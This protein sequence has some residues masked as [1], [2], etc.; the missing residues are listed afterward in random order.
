RGGIFLYTKTPPGVIGTSLTLKLSLE[1]GVKP[2]VIRGK[3][4]R[5][6]SDPETKG[7]TTLGVG[8]SFAGNDAATERALVEVIGRAMLGRGT[9]NRAFPRVYYLLEVKCRT[10]DELKALMRDIGEGGLGLTVDRALNNDEEVTVEI[11]R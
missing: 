7:R 9:R 11:T 4:A 1:G 6:A 5:I 10:K 2:L 8:V 3:I